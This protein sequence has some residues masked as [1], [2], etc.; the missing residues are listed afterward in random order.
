MKEYNQLINE[1]VTWADEAFRKD[2][3]DAEEA[4]PL[5]V[6][7]EK[8]GSGIVGDKEILSKELTEKEQTLEFARMQ[9][10]EDTLNSKKFMDMIEEIAM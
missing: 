9:A 5:Q 6:K 7:S 1:N 8:D 2:F 4:Q 3:V 10:I